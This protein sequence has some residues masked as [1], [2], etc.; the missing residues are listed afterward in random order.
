M[1]DSGVPDV[2]DSGV[3]DVLDAGVVNIFC[4]LIAVAILVAVMGFTLL[5]CA[6]CIPSPIPRPALSARTPLLRY[7][8]VAA[9]RP[10]R[11]RAGTAEDPFLV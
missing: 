9:I 7:L 10:F 3:S 11:F 1:S 2:L 6:L 5:W 8:G 4:V